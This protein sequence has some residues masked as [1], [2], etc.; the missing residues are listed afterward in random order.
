MTRGELYRV[1]KPGGDPKQYRIFVVVSRQVLIDSK[2]S[3]V[4]CAPVFTNGEGLST[5]VAVDLEEG[6][7]L[8]SWIMC[9]NLVSLRKT[10]LTNFVSSL[11]PAKLLEL[12]RALKMALGL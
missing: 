11:S 1:F 10:E 7:K 9:D 8:S 12:N 3:T 2:F 5:Q 6:W 4:I